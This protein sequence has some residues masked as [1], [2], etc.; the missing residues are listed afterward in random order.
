VSHP[1]QLGF[2]AACVAANRA[3]L[4]SARVLEI[5]SYD[6]NGSVRRLF[7]GTREYVG[8]DLVDGPGVDRVV[9]GSAIDDPDGSWDVTLSG[10]C[11]EHDP[12]WEDTLATMVRL[13]RP[14]GLVAF[15]C[16]SRG[17]IEHGTGRTT[18]AESPGTQSVG[19]D[20]YRNV[21]AAQVRSLPLD[22]WFSSWMLHHAPV[23]ADLYFAGVR[24]VGGEDDVIVAALPPRSSVESLAGLTSRR[25]RALRA[26]V[27]ALTHVI[28]DE[29]RFQQVATR[30]WRGVLV[31]G[32][33]AAGVIRAARRG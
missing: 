23:A 8:V 12:H 7:A 10:E 28:R 15:T 13:T 3:L 29:D 17:R 25:D 9:D 16:A 33:A 19:L 5:G 32:G 24:R 26:P 22:D 6:V 1:E 31:L 11:F 2:F 18:A 4:S 30:Y 14:G 27:R 21:S 20:H